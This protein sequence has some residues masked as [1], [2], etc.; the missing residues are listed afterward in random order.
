MPIAGNLSP[1]GI[2]TRN[3]IAIKMKPTIN[4]VLSSTLHKST[5]FTTTSKTYHLT[6]NLTDI[7]TVAD[8]IDIAPNRILL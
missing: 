5:P 3:P 2:V 8:K 1:I 7:K 4:A 6:I